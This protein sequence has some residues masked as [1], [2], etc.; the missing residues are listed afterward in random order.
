AGVAQGTG[1]V[2]GNRRRRPLES[3][4]HTVA[5]Y[6]PDGATSEGYARP[7]AIGTLK[8]N[9]VNAT[10]ELTNPSALQQLQA[11][12]VGPPVMTMTLP[13]SDPVMRSS[14]SWFRVC[15]VSSFLRASFALRL[16]S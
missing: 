8:R 1:S 5:G 14:F 11:S 13:S 7:V 4:V 6:H 10:V 16:A 9:A 12:V 2:D 15:Y 3:D